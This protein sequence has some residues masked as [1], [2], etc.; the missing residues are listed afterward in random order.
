[1]I[2]K[3]IIILLLMTEYPIIQVFLYQLLQYQLE[4]G[5]NIMALRISELYNFNSIIVYTDIFLDGDKLCLSLGYYRKC[6][7]V[8]I[9]YVKFVK[10]IVLIIF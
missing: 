10:Y 6:Y 8:A 2:E 7:K 5:M 9:K 4:Y 3:R 1:M